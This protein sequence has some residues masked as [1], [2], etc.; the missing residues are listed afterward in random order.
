[1]GGPAQFDSEEFQYPK[2]LIEIDGRPLIEQVVR[3]FDGIEQE[4]QYIFVVNSD[5]CK[6][7]HLDSVLEL[8]T[9]HGCVIIQLEKPTQGAAC[10]ALMAIEYIDNNE[11]LIISNSDHIIDYDLNLVL[12]RFEKRRVDAGT[13]CFES[14][15]P[16]WSF[17]R[18]DEN[19]KIVETAEKHPLSRDAIAGFYYFRKGND[20]VRSAMAMI[21]KDANV[22]GFYYVAPVINELVLENK[23]LEIFRIPFTAYHNFYSPHTIK[24]Y[25]A[26]LK[27]RR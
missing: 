3:C 23:N 10:S 20:F 25:E 14:V 26:Q 7:Y 13:I 8:I 4:K 22:N 9:G 21:Q 1:M 17:V 6:Q 18:L 5:D 11:P 27:S 12:E 16:K 24:E 2:P 19:E 15:H